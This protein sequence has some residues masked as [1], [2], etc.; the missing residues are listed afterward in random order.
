MFLGNG[1][2][3]FGPATGSPMLVPSPPYDDFASPY[4]GPI[5]TGDFN[6]SGHVGLAVGL[7]QNEAAVI[8]LGNG[9]GTFVASSAAAAKRGQPT[10]DVKAADF[11]GDGDLDLAIANQLTGTSPVVLGYGEGAF[12]AVGTLYTTGFPVAVAVGDFDADG[13]RMR[14]W[15]VVD[16]PYPGRDWPCPLEKET[17]HSCRRV[18]RRFPS[19]RIFLRS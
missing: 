1:D 11:N 3:T 18:V 6:H 9:N 4:T 14:L 12:T 10:S 19:G 7:F 16:R 5:A 15:P 8:L 13:R 2:G 17:G